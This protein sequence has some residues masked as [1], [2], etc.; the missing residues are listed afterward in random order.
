VNITFFIVGGAALT[1]AAVAF[2]ATLNSWGDQIEYRLAL[3]SRNKE[4]ANDRKARQMGRVSGGSVARQ[5][6]PEET[7]LPDGD[8]D[9]PMPTLRR[10]MAG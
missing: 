7:G 4:R 5:H 10:Y 9:V 6:Q 1:V 8:R 2:V 3:R